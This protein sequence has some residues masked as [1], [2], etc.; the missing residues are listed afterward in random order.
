M[1][2]KGSHK[3]YGGWEQ[4][5]CRDC[6]KKLTLESNAMAHY[7]DVTHRTWTLCGDCLVTMSQHAKG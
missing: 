7:D 6:G 4:K 1:V 2:A 3:T 5:V